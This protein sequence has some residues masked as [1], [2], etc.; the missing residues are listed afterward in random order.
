MASPLETLRKNLSAGGLCNI[1]RGQFEKITDTRRQTSIDYSLN[2]T[3]M[4]ALAMFQFKCPSLLQFDKVARAE[5]DQTVIGNLQRLYKLAGVP[6]DSQMRTILA[7]STNAGV[8]YRP[9]SLSRCNS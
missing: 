7:P 3:L 2:D 9:G 8:K 6:C 5:E 1:I 4:A